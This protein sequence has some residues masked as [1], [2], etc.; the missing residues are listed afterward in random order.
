[1]QNY[2]VFSQWNHQLKDFAGKDNQTFINFFNMVFSDLCCFL[3]Y[4][5]AYDCFNPKLK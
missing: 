1:M 3:C 4:K 5:D 2:Q